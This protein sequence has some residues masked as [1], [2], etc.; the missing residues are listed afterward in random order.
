MLVFLPP[1]QAALNHHEPERPPEP[2]LPTATDRALPWGLPTPLP[3]PWAGSPAATTE[4]GGRCLTQ[5]VACE[6]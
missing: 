6:V 4:N 3:L 1:L 2:T 5:P